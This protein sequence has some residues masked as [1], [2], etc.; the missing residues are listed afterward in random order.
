GLEIEVG[1]PIRVHYFTKDNGEKVV[2]ITFLSRS[3]STDVRLNEEHTEFEWTSIK[4]QQHAGFLYVSTMHVA[5]N[6]FA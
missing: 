2:M 3:G 5:C 6:H 4:F 1:P